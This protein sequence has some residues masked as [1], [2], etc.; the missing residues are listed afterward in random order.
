MLGA[1][2]KSPSELLCGGNTCGYLKP[3]AMLTVVSVIHSK[4][5]A[6]GPM[7][8]TESGSGHNFTTLYRA[9]GEVKRLLVGGC[10]LRSLRVGRQS[11]K[12]APIQSTQA[13]L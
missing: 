10:A 2:R 13:R 7:K 1:G 3:S 11:G 9:N 12:F 5:L 8:A 6:L 4:A